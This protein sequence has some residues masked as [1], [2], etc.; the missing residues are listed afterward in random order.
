MAHRWQHASLL[1]GR[2][3][4]FPSTHR[5]PPPRQIRFRPHQR[6]ARAHL[7]RW[8]CW[9]RLPLATRCGRRRRSFCRSCWPCFFRVDRQPH[10]AR[11]AQVVYPAVS[12]RFAHPVPGPGRHRDPGGATGRP[13]CRVGATGTAAHAADCPR[14]AQ[15]HQAGDAGQS[16]GGKIL[17]APPVA[18]ASAACRS[19]ARRWTTLQGPGPHAQARRVGV[20]GGAA[21]VLL[22]GL[23]RKP[24]AASR[25][26]LLPNRQQQRFTTEIM[27]DIEREVSRYVLTISVINTL[28]G[29]VFAG[30]FVC[31][32]D[33][34]AGSDLVGARW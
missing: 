30:I 28:V 13:G 8:W 15:S 27:L 23:W 9:P 18:K 12:R 34:A 3:C 31:T 19:C 20:G 5:M 25:S 21:D 6:T 24:A 11:S 17:H 22:H 7:P 26:P 29:L 32:E 10:P 2:V 4:L 14:C 16:G 33:S 1:P